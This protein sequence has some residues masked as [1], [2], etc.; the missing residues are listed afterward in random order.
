[1][2]GKEWTGPEDG[3]PP[4]GAECEFKHPDFG[5]TGCEVI[6]YYGSCAVCAPDGGGFYGG[7]VHDFRSLR[8][9]ED[10]TVE[11]MAMVIFKEGFSDDADH[12]S[13]ARA[14]YRAGC[15]MIERESDDA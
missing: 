12:V 14:L 8:T 11:K 13:Y 15:R 10:K 7:C 1:M 4:V 6:A 3:L 2:Q 9:E 5:W